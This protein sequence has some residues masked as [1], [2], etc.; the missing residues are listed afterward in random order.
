MCAVQ[1]GEKAQSPAEFE[2][3]P[4]WTWEDDWSFDS[5][6]AVDEKGHII[7]VLSLFSQLKYRVSA[8][9]VCHFSNQAGN[10]E[11]PFLLMISPNRGLQ[12]R[13]CTMSIAGRDS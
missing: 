11:L 10:M 5:N 12:L 13:R 2:C 3:P 7:T 1:N 4:G 6:R 8:I 9:T